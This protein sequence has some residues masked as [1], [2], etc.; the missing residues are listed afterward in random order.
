MA[1]SEVEPAHEAPVSFDDL[2]SSCL[3]VATR[4]LYPLKQLE[5]MTSTIILIKLGT[6][7]QFC[8]LFP[9]YS[10]DIQNHLLSHERFGK[11][12]SSVQL[13][14]TI[15]LKLKNRVIETRGGKEKNK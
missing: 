12:N 9:L 1:V 13:L 7:S 11:F 15:L 8:I 14:R 3:C 2:R 4:L 5:F 6:D 10:F